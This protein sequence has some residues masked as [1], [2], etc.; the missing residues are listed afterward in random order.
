MISIITRNYNDVGVKKQKILSSSV[1]YL[2][3]KLKINSE[4]T[5]IFTIILCTFP[6]LQ[7]FYLIFDLMISL[8]QISCYKNRAIYIKSDEQIIFFLL[9]S[10]ILLI[11]QTLISYMFFYLPI[12]KH[13]SGSAIVK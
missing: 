4:N 10:C 12:L 5:K 11:F 3:E 6:L 7:I 1:I 9:N 13:K 8:D 2:D